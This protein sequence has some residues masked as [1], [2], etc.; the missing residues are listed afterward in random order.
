MPTITLKDVS[1]HYNKKLCLENISLSIKPEQCWAIL[2]PNGSGKSALG[3]LLCQQLTP[4]SGDM[5]LENTTFVSFESVSEVLEQEQ[6]K[7]DSEFL[8][9]A[10]TGTLTRDFILAGKNAYKQELD[11]LALKLK[12]SHILERGIKFLSTG[13]MRKALIC[14]AL[15]DRPSHIVL[16]EPF[17]GL[18]SESNVSLQILIKE[19]LKD[20]TNII[21]LLNRFSEVLSEVTSLAYMQQGKIVIAGD[22][23][24][25]RE[26]VT[27]NRLISLQTS[28]PTKLPDMIYP[29]A[30]IETHASPIVMKN[31]C[32][33]YVGKPILTN[34]N[35]EVKPG[36]HWI[37]TGPNGSGKT[38]LLNLISG[39]NTQSY[40]NDIRLFGQ[41]KGMGESIWDIKK[42]IG[43]ISTAFQR[44]YR[45]SGTA[46]S[47]VVSGFFDSVG[48]YRKVSNAEKNIAL[49][50]LNILQMPDLANK[51]YQKLSFGEQR[52]VLLAR[53]MI[54][55]PEIL[56]LDEPCQGLDEI[57]REMILRVIDILASKGST[58]ILY[59]THAPQDRINCINNILHLIPS[60]QGGYTAITSQ[61]EQNK[62]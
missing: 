52:L 34:L 17:D 23:Q 3:R 12:F 55:H 8:G 38:T 2:G 10:D 40:S 62:L 59:V 24:S 57:N 44:S 36:E 60:D 35:W 29:R 37:I 5:E 42:R 43:I 58:Q 16:D 19:V 21:L 61:Y 26:S 11:A 54:K 46:L 22:K 45:V 31:I 41:Q 33:S 9:G 50:W 47:V 48:I 18:D 27:L 39:E 1:A 49:E 13:E 14:K 28:I 32:V 15:L 51:A 20:G 7:D 53:A 30:G 6:Y 56:I 4:S 25:V